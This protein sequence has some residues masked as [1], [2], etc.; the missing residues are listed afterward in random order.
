MIVWSRECKGSRGWSLGR[1]N[2]VQLTAPATAP[3][4]CQRAIDQSSPF[5]DTERSYLPF[6]SEAQNALLLASSCAERHC[7]LYAAWTRDSEC[8]PCFFLCRDD[9]QYANVRGNPLY[10][11]TKG[12]LTDKRLKTMKNARKR[13]ILFSLSFCSL[14]G[15]WKIV[16]MIKG[17]SPKICILCVRVKINKRSFE[18]FRVW[19]LF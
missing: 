19:I 14:F 3:S 11:T 12:H 7:S 13:L 5:S 16:G 6:G 18:P 15:A 9:K 4:T 8:S 10:Q 17:I 2:D 1:Q